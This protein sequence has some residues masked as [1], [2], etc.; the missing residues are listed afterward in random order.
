MQQYS[1]LIRMYQEIIYLVS[2]SKMGCKVVQ[3]LCMCK[4]MHIWFCTHEP[5]YSLRGKGQNFLQNCY[6][7]YEH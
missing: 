5:Q 2:H 4:D 7:N 1:K 6:T 3:V